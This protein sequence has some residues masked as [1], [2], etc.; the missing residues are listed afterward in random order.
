MQI[1]YA[2]FIENNS[3]E[4]S[5]EESRHISR[6]LRLNIG[7]PINITDG[8]GAMCECVLTEFG[9]R[10]VKASILKRTDSFEKRP[11][12]LHIAIAPTKNIDRFEWFVEKATELGIDEITPI[13]CEHSE[14]KVLRPE[15]IERV[16]VA[17]MKQSIKAYK[18]I[19]N[20]LQS[21]HDCIESSNSAECFIAH[22]HKS[23]KI[24]LKEL[25]FPAK[26]SLILIGPEGDFSETEVESAIGKDF[27]PISLGNSR[28]RTETA[29][30]VACTVVNMLNG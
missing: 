13:L 5:E 6:V 20:P 27:K 29:G 9:K 17:A 24:P 22:C 1:F 14:R 3:I 18:P 16:I 23:T 25:V 21:F 30:V 4:L 11:N 8:K 15:R 26:N 10:N 12:Y 7:D 19:L 2:P 28:L